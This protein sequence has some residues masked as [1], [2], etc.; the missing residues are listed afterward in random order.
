VAFER[1]VEAAGIKD[2]LKRQ[3][4]KLSGGQKRRSDIAR[5]LINTPKILFLD[6]PTTG[7]DPQTRKKVWETIVK[8]QRDSNM[9]V[10]L[11][12]H[13]MEEASEAD[14]VI[15][16]DNGKIAARGTP[17]ELRKYYANDSLRL[18]YL[19]QA[20]IE[21]ILKENNLGYMLRNGEA[22]IPLKATIDA[23]SILDLVRDQIKSFEVLSGTLNDA[24]IN[25]TGREIRE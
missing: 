17:Y 11:T 13:Y 10:F 19:D 21:A 23:L 25:I 12:T 5:A 2:F 22:I 24:F 15:I 8:M 6:E 14:Y 16:I 9:T 18:E 7:L 3:Y 1:V 20:A 4:K